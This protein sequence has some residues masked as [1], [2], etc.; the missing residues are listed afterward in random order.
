MKDCSRLFLFHISAMGGARRPVIAML[1]VALCLTFA[2]IPLGYGAAHARG[3]QSVADIADPLKAAVV[4]IST[5]QRLKEVQEVPLPEIPKDSPFEEFFQDFFNRDG[6]GSGQRSNS[7][8]SGFVID[9]S[10]LIVTNNHVIEG[11]DEITAV[12][13]DGTKLKVVEVVGRDAKTD[14]AV[15]RVEPPKPLSAVKF[16]D[17]EKMRVGDWVMAI[18]NPFGLGGTVTVGVVSATRRD[19][20]SGLYDEFLQTDASIN[21]GNSGGPLFNMDGE[22]IG[23]N[24]AIISPTGASIG[25]GF[26]VPSNTVAQVFDQLKTFGETR[27]GWLGVRIQTVTDEIAESVGLEASGGALVASVIEGGPAANAGLEVGDIVVS[28]DGQDVTAMRQLPKI[29][30]QTAI[31]KEVEVV[32]LRKGERMT[33]KITVGR[34]DEGGAEAAKP[35]AEGEKGGALDA[36]PKKSSLGITFSPITDELRSRYAIDRGV[37]GVVITEIDPEGPA[38]DKEV[39][40]GNVV[41]EI[42]HQKVGSPEEVTTRLE[43]LRKL[44]RRNALLTVAD[45]GGELSFVAIEIVAQ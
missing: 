29:V 43:T 32:V 11:A 7:L 44:K 42:T 5:T 34:L 1:A 45:S 39:Q 30:A 24:T 38:A 3:P 22:V 33:F 40:P 21:R 27:R 41:I 2:A 31:D 10:G 16:G 23:V 19:I 26:A 35:E 4:N 15:L 37:T 18:G 13:T 12:F 8:G 20:Q 14:L 9:A 28:F 6:P 17:S 36:Q 25:I